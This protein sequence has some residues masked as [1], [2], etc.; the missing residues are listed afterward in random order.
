MK[1]LVALVAALS[2]VFA[3]AD[4]FPSKPISIVVPF[5]AGGP[6]DRVARDLAEAMRKPLGDVSIVVDNV[7]GA[8]SSIGANKVAKAAPDGYVLLLNHIAMASMPNLLRKMPFNIE[9]DFEYLGMINDVPMTVIS[10][11]SLPA[12]NY[13]EF[14][15]WLGA[16]KGKINLGN[17]GIGSASH[18]CGL[19][20]QNALQIDMTAIPYKGTNPAMTDLIG[21]QIDLMCD[22]TTNTTGQIEG[23]K[24]NAYAVTTSKRLTTPALKDLPT[25][26]ESGLKGFEVTIWHGLYAPKGTPADVLAKINAALKAA[27][28]D[29]DFI[30]KQ[31]ALGAVVVNDKRVE[32]AEHKKF[33]AAEIAK[34][35]PVI[36]AAKEYID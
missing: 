33:V 3:F 6:T 7:A 29:P 17:A 34:W 24:V 8:G 15:A 10:K 1:K 32:P 26:Q 4:T 16:N 31:E 13:K 20:F 36:A 28:K 19:M 14:V 25:L 21:G 35:G 23:K 18:L 12:K 5:S 9:T 27:L 22:Q 30:K 2:A 11:P